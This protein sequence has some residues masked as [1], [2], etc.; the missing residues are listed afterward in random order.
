VLAN[1]QGAKIAA[2]LRDEGKVSFPLVTTGAPVDSLY[3]R[4]FGVENDV[5]QSGENIP[6]V[7]CYRDGDVIAG[8]I[9]RGGVEN[10][11][12]GRGG[13]SGYWSDPKMA[14]IICDLV[15]RPIKTTPAGP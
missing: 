6:W 10:L 8:S 1:S 11:L 12:I 9:E 14:K 4:F 7:N 13:H 3:R 2:D 5:N 15:E